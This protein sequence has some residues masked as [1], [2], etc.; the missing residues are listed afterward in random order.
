MPG[1]DDDEAKEGSRRKR[2]G[3]SQHRST[4]YGFP[5]WTENDNQMGWGMKSSAEHPQLSRWFGN[6]HIIFCT[7][8]PVYPH[9]FATSDSPPTGR[10]NVMWYKGSGKIKDIVGLARGVEPASRCSR[11]FHRGSSDAALL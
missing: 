7:S 10:T 2:S 6:N 9:N 5:R 4:A 8:S 11:Q 1:V 3:I